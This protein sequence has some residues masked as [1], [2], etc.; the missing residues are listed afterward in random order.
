MMK[1]EAETE[2]TKFKKFHK[3]NYAKFMD[4]EG[5]FMQPADA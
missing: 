2:F 1:E 4:A 5:E 3:K